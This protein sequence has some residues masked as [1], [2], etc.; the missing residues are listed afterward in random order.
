[1]TGTYCTPVVWNYA[2]VHWGLHVISIEI[3]ASAHSI[4]LHVKLITRPLIKK[5]LTLA[6]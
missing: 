1:M 6:S 5:C 2:H 3:A 4:S